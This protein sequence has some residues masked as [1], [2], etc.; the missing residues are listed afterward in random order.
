MIK[1]RLL[2][3]G[4]EIFAFRFV[5]LSVAYTG[6]WF[7]AFFVFSLTR[8]LQHMRFEVLF[9]EKSRLLGRGEEILMVWV[10][11][12]RVHC[13]SSFF[14][15]QDRHHPKAACFCVVLPV[16][17]SMHSCLSCFPSLRGFVA[18]FRVVFVPASC[19]GMAKGAARGGMGG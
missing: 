15:K 1:G 17:F 6:G 19:C 5:A 13:P 7:W 18:A 3:W 4:E 8:L 2:D 12:F 10:F 14:D 16:A 9:D 11:S